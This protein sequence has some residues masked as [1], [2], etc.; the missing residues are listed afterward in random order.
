MG[1]VDLTIFYTANNMNEL[2]IAKVKKK[3]TK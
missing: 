2:T 1:K 3:Q